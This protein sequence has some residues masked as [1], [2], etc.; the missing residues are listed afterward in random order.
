MNQRLK[1]IL[2]DILPPVVVN[3]GKFVFRSLY[4]HFN[5]PGIP[6]FEFGVEQPSEYYDKTF[7]STTNYRRHYTQS[8]YYPVWTVIL[9]RIR[10]QKNISLID[11]GCGSGQLACLMRDSGINSY[12]GV[13]FS[14]LRIEHAK[15]I[16][17]EFRFYN[18]D[19]FQEAVF[20]QFEYNTVV[21]LEFLEHVQDDLGLLSNL[22]KGTRVLASV[23]N[24]PDQGHVR[25][26]KNEKEVSLRYSAVIE[27]LNVTKI[28]SSSSG[29]AFFIVEGILR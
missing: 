22:K 27:Q 8:S 4:S 26:F 10:A 16:C 29:A 6:G 15:S 20:D 24:F 28:V 11:I 19:V 21:I 18:L 7:Q 12:T 2:S 3:G 5:T 14:K 17:P 9:D 23:P 1:R 25:L 13:D